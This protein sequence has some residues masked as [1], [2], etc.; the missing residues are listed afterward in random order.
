VTPSPH[1]WPFVDGTPD[2]WYGAYPQTCFLAEIYPGGISRVTIST[3]SIETY[4]DDFQYG[5]LTPEPSSLLLMIVGGAAILNLRKRIEIRCNR[6]SS[7]D[8]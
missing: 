1:V 8:A 5:Q 6:S 3:P 2:E 4:I 7:G